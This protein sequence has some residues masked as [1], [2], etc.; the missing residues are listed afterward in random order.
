MTSHE[1]DAYCDTLPADCFAMPYH[2]DLLLQQMQDENEM[3]VAREN[4]LKKAGAMEALGELKHY[5][6]LCAVDDR[7]RDE[8]FGLKWSID[9]ITRRLSDIEIS[10]ATEGG[11]A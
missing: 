11:A 1:F 4:A 2:E 9:A 3:Q 6:L 8:F 10:V 7:C 5:L